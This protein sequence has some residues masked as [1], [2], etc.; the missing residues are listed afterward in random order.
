[1]PLETIDRLGL[2]RA[3]KRLLPKMD[4]G[5]RGGDEQREFIR[6]AARNPT[7]FC[8]LVRSWGLTGGDPPPITERRL[9]EKEFTDPPWST[10]CII[11]TTWEGLPPSLAARPETW[12]RIHVE[13][14]EQGRI[15]STYLAAN[16]NGETGRARIAQALNGNDAQ[17]VDRCVRTVLRRLGGVVEDRANR[18]AFIDCPLAKAW[19][20]NRYAQEACRTFNKD[21]AKDLS[22]ALRP[23]FRWTKLVEAMISRL[24]V[25]GD[26]AIRP[27]VVQCLAD[28][29]GR[30]ASEMEEALRWI[31]RRATIQAL[32]F[33]GADMVLQTIENEFLPKRRETE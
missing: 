19:W 3:Q 5:L 28:G 20:R 25:I 33:L 23:T 1:M 18:T 31:G 17:A 27:A 30:N 6:L 13:M 26:S 21:P 9:T 8:L 15:K 22:A 10:E 14:V 24:T 29:I 16:G 2:E 32:G 7:E 4:S 11:A 12:G